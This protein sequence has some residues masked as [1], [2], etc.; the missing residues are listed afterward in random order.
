MT[1]FCQYF[2]GPAERR[3][4]PGPA[5]ADRL[6]ET[7]RLSPDY[8]AD[9]CVRRSSFLTI[10]SRVRPAIRWF[11]MTIRCGEAQPFMFD[12]GLRRR[13]RSRYA[14]HREPLGPL[15]RI[16]EFIIATQPEGDGR[17]IA[18][19]GHVYTARPPLSSARHA[20]RYF[21][22]DRSDSLPRRIRPSVIRRHHPRT[23][24]HA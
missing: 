12:E 18:R 6:W 14:G 21:A 5:F 9:I 19:S 22:P 10:E 3:G 13:Y 11:G 23:P 20:L 15:P 8:L 17:A 1:F 4:C 16:C 24:R 7:S 2:P